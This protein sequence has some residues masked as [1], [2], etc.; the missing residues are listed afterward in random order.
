M[1][2]R[3]GDAIADIESSTTDL[4]G[5]NAPF[6]HHARFPSHAIQQELG[7]DVLGIAGSNVDLNPGQ[8]VGS[9]G[10]VVCVEEVRQEVNGVI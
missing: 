10:V 3:D 9:D 5:L 6:T 7:R 1:N 8:T 4:V 2:H